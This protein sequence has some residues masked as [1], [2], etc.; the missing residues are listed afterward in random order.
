[1]ILTN[2]QILE[3]AREKFDDACVCLSKAKKADDK[4]WIELEMEN[5]KFWNRF[6]CEIQRMEQE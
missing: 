4:M 3:K 2:Q 6:M 1:M 5:A